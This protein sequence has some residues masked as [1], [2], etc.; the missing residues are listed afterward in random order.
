MTKDNP[1]QE[2]VFRDGEGDAWFERNRAGLTRER[3]EAD[4]PVR[5]LAQLDDDETA[6]SVLELGCANGWRLAQL[7]HR[8][9]GGRHVGVEISA[10]A[11]E[12]GR[13]QFDGLEFHQGSIVDVPLDEKFDIVIVNFVLHWID[14]SLLSRAIAEIDRLTKDG[15]YLLVGD[16]YPDSPVKRNYK[17]LE[18]E[19][20]YTFKQDYPEI[21]R[22]L[23]TYKIASKLSGVAG[24]TE[25]QVTVRWGDH[26]D[27]TGFSLMKKS[28]QDF[29]I[30]QL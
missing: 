10:K 14:R 17:H 9:I 27:R 25:P 5:L 24:V 21:F 4:W 12:D 7:K 20:V 23:G 15:G 3:G 28:L 11:I 8:G 2:R 6:G 26:Q 19:E 29:Y 18:Q 22:S 30:E 13:Q 1:T 16:F